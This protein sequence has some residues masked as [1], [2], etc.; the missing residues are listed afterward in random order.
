MKTFKLIYLPTG[1]TE[2][3]RQGNDITVQASSE[4]GAK[5]KITRSGSYYNWD[6][7]AVVEVA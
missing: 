2:K 1:R 6:L 5:A 4:R 3:D 7:T